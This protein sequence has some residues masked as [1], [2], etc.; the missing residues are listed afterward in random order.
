MNLQEHIL[1]GPN[2]GA[3]D[4]ADLRRLLQCQ[5]VLGGSGP[6]DP[7]TPG[8]VVPHQVG[9][10]RACELALRSRFGVGNAGGAGTS[11]ESVSDLFANVAV[12]VT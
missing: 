8:P 1:R 9:P 2:G 7:W 5:L 10:C 12:L 11:P 6:V 4:L 3:M